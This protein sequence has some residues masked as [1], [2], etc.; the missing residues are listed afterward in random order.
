M[1]VD[2]HKDELIKLISS[3]SILLEQS[4]LNLG[5]F[6]ETYDYIHYPLGEV[7]KFISSLQHTIDLQYKLINVLNNID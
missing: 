3:L 2:L 5:V 7:E 1:V 4:K 6:N